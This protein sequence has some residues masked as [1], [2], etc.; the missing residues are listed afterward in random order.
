MEDK[1]NL[2]LTQINLENKE[3]FK[4]GKQTKIKC[5]KTKDKYIFCLNLNKDLP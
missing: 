5:N 2:L 3:Y 4:G 1:L